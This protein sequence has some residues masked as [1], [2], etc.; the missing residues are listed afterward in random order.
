MILPNYGLM[1]CVLGGHAY[2]SVSRLVFLFV[3][4]I[5]FFIYFYLCV[6]ISDA[7]CPFFFRSAL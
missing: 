7:L 4:F 2:I 5:C 1:C 6:F 3:F